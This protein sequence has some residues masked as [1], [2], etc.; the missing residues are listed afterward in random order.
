MIRQRS[1]TEM[2][3]RGISGVGG[4]TCLGSIGGNSYFS[5]VPCGRSRSIVVGSLSVALS[6]SAGGS[7]WAKLLALVTPSKAT[8]INFNTGRFRDRTR[9]GVLI[10]PRRRFA[11]LSR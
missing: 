5:G 1:G 10:A 9:A 7:V 2:D 3:S 8:T 4:G 11:R 6:G